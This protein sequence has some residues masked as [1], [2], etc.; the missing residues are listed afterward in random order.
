MTAS[1]DNP[2][3]VHGVRLEIHGQVA[4]VVLDRAPVNAVTVGMYE[5]LITVFRELSTRTDVHAVILRSAVRIFSAGADIKQPVEAVS[6]SE[7]AAEFRQRMARTAYEA[8]LD[9]TLPTIAVINGAAVG[10]GAV[11]GACCDIR[12]AAD[13]ARIGLPEINAGRCGGGAH[14]M[15]LLPQGQVRLM[16][17]TGDPVDAAEAYRTG[18]VQHVAAPD[19][20]LTE[21]R[22]LAARIAAKSP[23]GLRLA[24]QALNEAENLP[25]RPGYAAEQVYTL[26]LGA[27]PDAAEAAKAVLDKREAVWSWPGVAE[28]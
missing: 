6:P 26:R 13:D 17:L 8:I 20:I 14:L 25:V 11:L 1:A 23:L 18:L 10:A 12:Y 2:T 21:A 7:S 24:K 22:E 28:G 4:E 27:H 3:T 19:A 5:T 15:R 9:C 16:Y